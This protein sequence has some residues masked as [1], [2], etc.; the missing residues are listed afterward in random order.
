LPQKPAFLHSPKVMWIIPRFLLSW[1]RDLRPHLIL[2]SVLTEQL[3]HF[4]FKDGSILPQLR[5]CFDTNGKVCSTTQQKKS[6][7]NCLHLTIS[8]S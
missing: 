2:K 6:I 8:C 3:V 1:R 5:D 4:C 7:K